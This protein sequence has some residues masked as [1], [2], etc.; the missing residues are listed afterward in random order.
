[1]AGNLENDICFHLYAQAPE[2]YKAP[3]FSF[4]SSSLHFLEPRITLRRVLTTF[5]PSFS[6]LTVSYSI[7]S[8]FC[9]SDILVS[10]FSS[11]LEIILGVPQ[12]SILGPPLLFNIFINDL[13]YIIEKTKLCNFADDNTIYSCHTSVDAIITNLEIDLSDVLEWFKKNQLAANPDKFQMIV[14]SLKLCTNMG[15]HIVNSTNEVKL[16]GLIID[17][18]LNFNSHINTLYITASKKL[19]CLRRIR[20]IILVYRKQRFY[21]ILIYIQ[22]LIIVH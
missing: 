22:H 1:M 15:K 7:P 13:F 2:S 12:G 20:K 19:K 9:Y 14:L 16:L 11:W 6:N 3:S 17:H 4:S 8:I 5:F 18:K 21:V 10:Y